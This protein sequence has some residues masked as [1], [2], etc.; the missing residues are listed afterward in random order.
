M[1][2]TMENACKEDFI[3]FP[4]EERIDKVGGGDRKVSGAQGKGGLRGMMLMIALNSYKL[5]SRLQ[6]FTALYIDG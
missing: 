6:E 5:L 3:I 2:L 1:L 4:N